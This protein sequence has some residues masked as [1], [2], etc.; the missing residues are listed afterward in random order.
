VPPDPD[1]PPPVELWN[2]VGDVRPWATLL[3]LCA[4]STLFLLL[5][6]RHALSGDDSLLEW[7]ANATGMPAADTA[8]R[9]L[10]STFLHSGP[11][12][13]FFNATTLLIFGPAVERLFT[14]WGF[15]ITYGAGGVCASLASLAWRGAH[16]P[17]FSYSV[18]ASGAIFALGGALIVAAW[19]LRHR[20]A[21]GRARSLAAAVIYLAGTG[22]AAGF[23]K[24]GTDNIAH[25]A[26]LA[27]GA[28]IAALMNFD[29]RL[30]G[31]GAGWLTRSAGFLALLAL[32]GSLAWAVLSGLGVR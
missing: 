4:C 24:N 18:G 15:W 2:T 22:F 11:A 16:K 25:A 12:H 30:G 3:V 23:T 8:W 17:G 6:G 28:A 29:P 13:L 10:A 1:E 27:S 9:L 31:K 5:A 32:A 26:G 20:L 19:R 7:G 21:V 14:R